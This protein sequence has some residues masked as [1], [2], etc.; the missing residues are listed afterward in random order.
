MTRIQWLLLDV[1]GNAL[2]GVLE[3]LQ[4]VWNHFLKFSFL[5]RCLLQLDL[6]LSAEVRVHHPA[7][8]QNNSPNRFCR[9]QLA[10]LPSVDDCRVGDHAQ[11]RE[12]NPADDPRADPDWR[13]QWRRRRWR[14]TKGASEAVRFFPCATLC[15]GYARGRTLEP[16]PGGLFLQ[17]ENSKDPGTPLREKPGSETG[18]QGDSRPG[19]V[20][21]PPSTEPIPW[22]PESSPTRPA[23][24]SEQAAS[25]RLP[26]PSTRPMGNSGTASSGTCQ[27]AGGDHK[28]QSQYD[29]ETDENPCVA[30]TLFGLLLR[31]TASLNLARSPDCA[32]RRVANLLINAQGNRT[33]IEIWHETKTL[34]R[35]AMFRGRTLRNGGKPASSTT[36]RR[37]ALGTTPRNTLNAAL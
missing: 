34:K 30:K 19:M 23:A 17:A 35:A 22:Q 7:K 29:D 5:F 4:H 11:S 21:L 28:Y 27:H 6:L 13:V 37:D 16:S 3:C 32:G 10:V 24:I 14:R 15:G 8:G 36:M 1:A 2:L 26:N 31:V 25:F 12:P 18:R 20:G 9:G 33:G